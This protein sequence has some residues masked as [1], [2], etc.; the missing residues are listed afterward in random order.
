MKRCLKHSGLLLVKVSFQGCNKQSTTP[1]KRNKSVRRA[2]P[3]MFDAPCQPASR[4]QL[5]SIQHILEWL[6][7]A[8]RGYIKAYI[9]CTVSH[10]AT[11]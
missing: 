11:E 9:V 3:A 8:L 6:Y 7:H 10:T 1:V 5:T 4:C 2:D